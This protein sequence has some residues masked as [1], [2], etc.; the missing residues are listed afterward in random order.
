MKSMHKQRLD[1][2]IAHLLSLGC[3][4]LLVEHPV[5]LFY[6]TGLELSA[7]KLLV[8]TEGA[9][10]VVDGRYYEACQHEAPCPVERL[11]EDTIQKWLVSTGI[12]QLAFDSKSTSYQ[13]FVQLEAAVGKDAALM[14]VDE[15][16]QPL[17][18]I[19]DQGE[20]DLMHAAGKLCVAGF[21]YVA[22]LLKEG[23]VE[24]DL[25][26]KLELFWKQRGAK[27][28]SFD[29]IIAFGANSSMPHYRAGKGI[30]KTGMSVLIDIGVTVN[31]YQSDMTRV[32]FF[33]EP[34]PHIKEIY[35][36]VEEAKRRALA[37][38][39]PG[40]LVRDLDDAA[41]SY[42]AGQGYGDRFTHSLGHGVGLDIHEY[43]LIRTTG[44]A[45]QL[46]L[47][48]GMVITIEPGI[49]LP[50]IGGVRLED[51]VLINHEGYKLLTAT[52]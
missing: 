12:R 3:Q 2:L 25:A 31:H 6:L 50:G 33:G 9:R 11:E 48:A 38:C 43:P 10:L 30:L 4:G 17:R 21:N 19:K 36:I 26:L 14:A 32:V 15:P 13:R 27:K 16:L 41:R 49:Y 18:L 22:S 24:E 29:P 28:L 39:H 40:T 20:I 47:Q 5:D 23:A 52:S 35:L 44:A 8:T 45:S 34:N 1:N 51:T 37:L 46:A 42:I 7:G